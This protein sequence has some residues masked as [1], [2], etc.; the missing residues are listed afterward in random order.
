ML[1]PLFAIGIKEGLLVAIPGAPPRAIQAYCLLTSNC[2]CSEAISSFS[3]SQ[4]IAR[5]KM[6][7]AFEDA[8]GENAARGLRDLLKGTNW[9]LV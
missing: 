2:K 9:L 6:P 7:Q 4:S 3:S 1:L 5:A 8:N